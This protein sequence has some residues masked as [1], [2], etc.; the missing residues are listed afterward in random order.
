MKG[1]ALCIALAV[2]LLLCSYATAQDERIPT[3]IESHTE[4]ASGWNEPDSPLLALARADGLIYLEDI[5]APLKEFLQLRA[6]CVFDALSPSQLIGRLAWVTELDL[7]PYQ[8]TL[9]DARW[10]WMFQGLTRITLTDASLTDLN[11]IAE[12]TGLEELTLLNCGVFDLTP[13]QNCNHLATLTL[14]WDDEY[15]GA[16]GAFDLSPLETLEKLQ[17]LALYGNGIVSIEPLIKTARHILTLTLSDTAI[18]D[19]AALEH[20]KKLDTL[21]LDLLHSDAAAETLRACP[22]RIHALT[23][24]RIIFDTD[25]QDAAR[26]FSRLSDFTLTDCDAANPLF[27]EALSK[28]TR[29]TLESVSMPDGESIGKLYADKTTL[30]LRDVPEAVMLYMLH[31]KS[32]NLKA[33]TIDLET[34]SSELSA[35]LKR[36]TSLNTLTIGLKTNADLSGEAWGRLTGLRDLTIESQGKTL[37]STDF[38]GEL[39]N[40]DTLTLSGVKIDQTAGIGTLPRL[41]RLNVYGCRIADWSFL[42]ALQGLNAVKVYASQ[43]TNETLP[44]FASLR[45]LDDLRLDGNE[46]TSIAALTNSRTIRKLDILDNPIANYT[47]LLLMPALRTVYSNESGV[48]TDN[49]IL[50]RSVYIDDVDYEAIEQA[51]FGD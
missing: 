28:A 19:I 21:T 25:T 38:L 3:D 44:Y 8:G 45:A 50:V 51:A 9:T 10:L 37:L 30:V 5:D 22:Q 47:P 39:V 42:A 1:R 49:R 46:I 27:Y 35:E 24:S 34:M 36:K 33:L 7:S 14:G 16:A 23:L 13:L 12:F 43:L 15:T 4:N 40:L 29:L 20:F 48:I 2:F 26:R 18:G 11:V 17:T 31:N 41:G 6:R 32:S